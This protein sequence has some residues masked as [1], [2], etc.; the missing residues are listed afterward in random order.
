LHDV[1]GLVLEMDLPLSLA[2]QRVIDEL[3]RRYVDRVL[4]KHGGNVTR[5]A[6]ASGIARRYFHTL[7]ARHRV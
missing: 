6:H 2:R 3:E 1:L 4:A 5:A 7:R